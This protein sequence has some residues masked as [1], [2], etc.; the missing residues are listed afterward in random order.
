MRKPALIL[1]VL[2]LSVAAAGA[3]EGG[4]PGH[5]A[6]KAGFEPFGEFHRILAPAWHGAWPDKDYEALLTA[7]PKF[8]EAFAGIAKLDPTFKTKKRAEQFKANRQAFAKIV[9]QYADAAEAGDK[10]K[11][12][13]LM[14]ELHETFEQTASSLLPIHYPE[15]DV[16]VMTVNLLTETHLPNDS[17]EGIVGSTETLVAK[18][19]C[20]S[21]ETIPEELSEKEKEIMADIAVMKRLITQM[22]EYC[23]KNDMDNYKARAESL[24]EK[25]NDFIKKYI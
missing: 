22:K 3:D 17:M 19:E 14:P 8:A 6:A 10:E 2:L 25:V 21:K 5:R 4:C 13:D 15:F 12:Y 18:I 11:V 9:K 24:N 23:D 16:L 7:G 20:L 1:S